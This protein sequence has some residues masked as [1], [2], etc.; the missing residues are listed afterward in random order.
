MKKVYF[1]F[2]AF[3]GFS[4]LTNAQTYLFEDF[5][6]DVMPPNGWTIDGYS[7]LWSTASS[8]EAGGI[9]P[10][11]KFTYTNA[12]AVSRFISP[13]IDLT[14]VTNVNFSFK[15]FLDN[16]SSGPKIGV[17]TRSGGGDW[18]IVWEINTTS[19][20][21]PEEKI[22]AIANDDVGQSDFQVCLYL[23]GNFYNI[24][25][26]YIDD[27][28][29]YTP[30]NLDAKLTNI[31]TPWYLSGANEVSGSIKNRGIQDL[32]SL[33][34]SWQVDK[35]DITV[36]TVSDLEISTGESFNYTC[37][38][39][40]DFPVGNHDL[41]VWISG[42]NNGIDDDTENNMLM[43]TIHVASSTDNR[44]PLFEEFTSST[45]PPC[46]T[47]NSS[48]VPWCNNNAEDITLVKYQMSWPSPG[49]PYYTE[50][51]GDRRAYYGVSFVPDLYGNGAQV[52]TNIG[53]VNTFFNTA[54]ELPGF[55]SIVGSNTLDGTE[56]TIDI[57]IL[58]YADYSNFRLYVV[59]FEY[60]TVDNIPNSNWNG[61]TE[62]E[63]VMMKMVP[64]AFGTTL[65]LMD[66][67]PYSFSQTIDLE[68]TNVE[69]W[70]DLG[71]AYIF[72]DYQGQEVFQS[73]YAT[74]DGEFET[75]AGLSNIF[76][77]GE[78]IEDFS[79]EV[80]N[81]YIELP[82]GTTEIP[83][84]TAIPEDEKAIVVIVP[85]DELRNNVTDIDV[86]AEDL[87]THQKYTV[88]FTLA[89]GLD[90]F[91]DSNIK[92]YP[93]PTKGIL[94]VH[95]NDHASVFI[96]AA[97]GNLISNYQVINHKQINLSHL[98]NGIYFIKIMTDNQVITKKI[99]LNK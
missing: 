80:F 2:I 99:S 13:E 20:I 7:N 4:F 1:L 79:P 25:Y 6:D 83:E 55:A 70:D 31:S 43:K 41:E 85:A 38:G 48:F 57:N 90:P 10:E 67:Q 44:I 86:F 30:Y 26:W 63:N 94:N 32:T 11:A 88:T 5:S 27:I 46:A 19:N 91:I 96:Y 97:D 50:E 36:T 69:E 54:M 3:L 78:P 82:E 35:G 51:G 77:D 23:D 62:F 92:L 21:G 76:V 65:N 28:E 42:V 17:A 47:F 29:L 81:Y 68:G 53:A 34:I 15:H 49:D 71:V 8:D 87:Y 40:F 16:Y 95:T 66:R 9:A 45:C 12:T 60:I 14:G 39:I 24:D 73:G 52:A 58:P 61:E 59:V 74:E 37:D 18:N 33:E 56:M 84:V 98:S 75:M 72:Q 89:T 93:N 64:D 22:I